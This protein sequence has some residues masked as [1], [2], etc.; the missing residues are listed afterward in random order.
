MI[1]GRCCGEVGQDCLDAGRV[2]MDEPADLLESPRSAKAAKTGCGRSGVDR[3]GRSRGTVGHAAIH[4][5]VAAGLV[6]GAAS[7]ALAAQVVGWNGYLMG[8]TAEKLQSS[9][10]MAL[11]PL[12]GFF[13]RATAAVLARCCRRSSLAGPRTTGKTPG[14]S[15]RP[16]G[17]EY[18]W[19]QMAP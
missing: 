2:L 6:L 19:R 5:R 9:W 11:F 12:R 10:R 15:S 4:R 13:H 7:L 14:S 8:W 16:L 17:S 3:I 1:D 18:R